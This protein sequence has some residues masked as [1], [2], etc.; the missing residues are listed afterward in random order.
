VPGAWAASVLDWLVRLV[1]EL[2]RFRG[3]RWR[4]LDV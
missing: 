2:I 4:E 3:G 1:L